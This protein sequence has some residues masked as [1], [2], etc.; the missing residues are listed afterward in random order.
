MRL[1]HGGV[2]CDRRVLHVG[3]SAEVMDLAWTPGIAAEPRGSS[4]VKF[5]RSANCSTS[6]G[7]IESRIETGTA[8]EMAVG[9]GEPVSSARINVMVWA[10]G[11]RV[12]TLMEDQ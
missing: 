3:E 7:R 1:G 9:A 6:H 11:R 8:T 2:A 4:S 5:G 10:D 12:Q